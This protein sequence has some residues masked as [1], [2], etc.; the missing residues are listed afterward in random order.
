MVGGFII[1]ICK[2]FFFHARRRVWVLRHLAL[3]LVRT[4]RVGTTSSSQLRRHSALGLVSRSRASRWSLALGRR[5]R[6]ALELETS[7]RAPYILFRVLR[8]VV[9]QC[10][11]PQEKNKIFERERDRLSELG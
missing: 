11:S 3:G 1:I 5:Y 4:L 7:P 2:F 9:I 10:V 6:S 8:E